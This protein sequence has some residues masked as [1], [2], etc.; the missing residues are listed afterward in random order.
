M[1]FPRERLLSLGYAF[2]SAMLFAAHPVH[3]EAVTGIVGRAEPLSAMFGL[4]ALAVFSRT[5]SAVQDAVHW[6]MLILSGVL[7]WLAI[8]SKETAI[9]FV[10]LVLLHDFS[11]V[12]A[13]VQSVPD[14][15]ESA[16]QRTL[17]LHGL[18]DRTV[19]LATICSLYLWI[20]AQVGR[21]AC[22]GLRS[23]RMS[24]V[25]DGCGDG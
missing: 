13:R 9:T 22:N 2:G 4:L 25:Q 19:F 18:R 6:P 17:A 20:R 12:L 21:N 8:L 7:V 14:T 1:A 5:Y 16:G 24:A 15:L 3:T 10:A 23:Q 11:H